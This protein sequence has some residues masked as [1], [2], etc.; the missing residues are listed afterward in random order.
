MASLQEAILA[1]D[2]PKTTKK[3]STDTPKKKRKENRKEEISVNHV[4]PLRCIFQLT[5]EHLATFSIFFTHIHEI[6]SIRI[7]HLKA[8]TL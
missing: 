7:H 1:H 5:P 3:H 6:I 4:S 8:N 2:L